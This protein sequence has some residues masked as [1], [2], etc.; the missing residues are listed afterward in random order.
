[1][2]GITTGVFSDGEYAALKY[3]DFKFDSESIHV[4]SKEPLEYFHTV[5]EVWLASYNM[6]D[7]FDI[8][9]DANSTSD[10]RVSYWVTLKL[11]DKYKNAK[12]LLDSA[13]ISITLKIDT[14][15]TYKQIESYGTS[16]KTKND[17]AY[18]YFHFYNESSLFTGDT[19]SASSSVF[20][21]S[22]KEYYGMD[23]SYEADFFGGTGTLIIYDK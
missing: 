18:L 5:D 19:Q 17:S 10:T 12:I 16:T 14:E 21:S 20:I 3:Q 13:S 1:M 6:D 23:I 8:Y 15:Y 2:L 22:L 9:V 7:Y 11:K 4:G